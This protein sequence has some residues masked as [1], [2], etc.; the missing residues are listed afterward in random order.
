M[1]EASA[2]FAGHFRLALCRVSPKKKNDI[3]LIRNKRLQKRITEGRFTLPAAILLSVAGWLLS[4][5]LFP[6]PDCGEEDYLLARLISGWGVSTHLAGACGFLLYAFT[7]YLLIELNNRF[8]LIRMRAS[9]QTAVYFLLIAV[10]PAM[11]RLCA[12]DVAALCFL[13]SLF[14]LFAG[15]QHSRPAGCL[16]HA[17]TFIGL[18]SLFLPQLTLFVPLYWLGARSFQS[19]SLKSLLGGLLGW[20]LPY[21]FLFAH[22]YYHGEMHL[23]HAPFA[24][25]AH[26]RPM[27]FSCL[28][29]SDVLTAGY[30]FVLFAVSAVHCFVAGYEDKIRT[31]AFLQHL[32]LF[33]FCL[34][35]YMALQPSLFFRLLPMLIICTSILAGHLLV[36]TATRSSNLFFITIAA[37]WLALLG[38]NLWTLL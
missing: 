7:G 16:F 32:I 12:A 10:C 21:W 31:R 17:F 22:A 26:F 23:F 6:V 28:T 33:T 9:F 14:F 11:H 35:L 29:L 15:Y 8:A 2:L 5:L 30:L 37:G 19:L 4:G 18:G 3:I 38:V 36:L 25:L 20:S 13:C 1:R 27:D 34:F 24:E